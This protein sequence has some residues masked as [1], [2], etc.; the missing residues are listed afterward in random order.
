MSHKRHRVLY[1]CQ[2]IDG[3][4]GFK[5]HA[6]DF[7]NDRVKGGYIKGRRHATSFAL[8]SGLAGFPLFTCLRACVNV[9]DDRER[10]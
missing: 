10:P 9:I 6:A 3:R 2:A 7:K 1:Y 8:S 5:C 4:V